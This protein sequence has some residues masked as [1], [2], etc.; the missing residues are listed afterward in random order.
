MSWRERTV[1]RAIGAMGMGGTPGADP[2]GL[3]APLSGFA[4]GLLGLDMGPTGR[5]VEVGARLRGGRRVWL[6]PILLG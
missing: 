4:V 2:G 1:V 3:T 6:L 5:T